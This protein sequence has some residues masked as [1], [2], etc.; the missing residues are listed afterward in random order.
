MFFVLSDQR[1]LIIGASYTA[2]DLA[3][4]T[5]KYDAK[6]VICSYRTKPMAFKWCKGVEERP[7]LMKMEGKKAFFKDGTTAEVNY[8]ITE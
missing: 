6:H 4:Q 7:L 5:I 1:L 8:Y 2:E 3:I